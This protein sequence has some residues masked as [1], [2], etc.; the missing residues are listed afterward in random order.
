MDKQPETAAQRAEEHQQSCR[1]APTREDGSAVQ[2]SPSS[3]SAEKPSEGAMQGGQH[4]SSIIEAGRVEEVYF[5][6][7]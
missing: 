2:A 1:G 4:P 3:P 5:G 7:V 6:V